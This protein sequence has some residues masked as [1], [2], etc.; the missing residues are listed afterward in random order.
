MKQDRLREHLEQLA[1][2]KQ[3]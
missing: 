2:I 1:S 3:H